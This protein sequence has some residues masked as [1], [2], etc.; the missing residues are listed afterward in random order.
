MRLLLDTHVAIWA[1]QDDARLPTAIKQ[2]I[3][4]PRNEVAVSA[5]SIWEI[6]I[7]SSL[8]RRGLGKMPVSASEALRLFIETDFDMLSLTAEHALAVEDLPA[9]HGDP[10]D[11]LIVAQSLTE[12]MRLVTHDDTV[13]AYNSSIIHF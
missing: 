2:M 12:P 13:A 7:K 5:V 10:F 11:R 6:A 8:D 1:V 4:S 9:L 3:A